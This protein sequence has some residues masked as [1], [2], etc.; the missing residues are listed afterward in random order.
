MLHRNSSILFALFL[1]AFPAF[2]QNLSEG[3]RFFAPSS[4]NGKTEL[5]ISGKKREYFT[6]QEGQQIQ[7]A[8]KGPSQLKILSRAELSGKADSLQYK[9]LVLRKGSRKTT[10]ISHSTYASDKAAFTDASAGAVSVSRTKVLDIPR[11]EQLYTF[12]LPKGTQQKLFLRFAL[13]TNVFTDGTSV[14]ALTPEQFTTQVDMVSGEEVTVYYRIGTG[15][16]TSLKLI[17]PATLK[18]M[19]RIEYD[20]NMTGKQKWRVQVAEDSRIK[21]TYSLA[22]LKSDVMSYR[23]QSPF[24]VSRAETFYVEVPAGE[25]RYD[26]IM[27]DNHRTCL[28]R[29]LLPES[30]LDRE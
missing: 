8:V 15:Y 13:A 30:Q 27:P 25:H 2:G 12:Y 24:V 22:S 10:T 23:E 1:L 19:A 3:F 9:I 21:S 16:N 7:V 14:V 26:F 11:G 6:L 17:G 5:S 28:L 20:V 18:V 4:F 29:F